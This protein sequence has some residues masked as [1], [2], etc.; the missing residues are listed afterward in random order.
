MAP[1]SDESRPRRSAV[2]VRIARYFGLLGVGAEAAAA[3]AA[4]SF[5]HRTPAGRFRFT[6]RHSY[7]DIIV[8]G[9]VFE[10]DRI[11]AGEHWVGELDVFRETPQPFAR[12]WVDYLCTTVTIRISREVLRSWAVRDLT[13]QRMLFQVLTDRQGVMNIVYGLDHRSTLARVAQLLDYLAHT[14]AFLEKVG[15][16][17]RGGATLHGP[18][19]KH[20]ADALGLSLTSVEKSM[21]LLRKHEIL[22]SVGGG[23]AHRTY[24]IKQPQLLEAVAQGHALA[25]A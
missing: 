14:P 7:V 11:W 9:V 10:A 16:G 4:G 1:P 24:S 18:T 23:R 8:D 21:N 6:S 17:F 15:L 12:T 22:A 13:V 2:E 3:L 20:L 5:L 25:A 19:Q